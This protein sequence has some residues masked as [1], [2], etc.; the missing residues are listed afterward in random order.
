LFPLP[1]LLAPPLPLP[2]L[3]P[4]LRP[5]AY[6]APTLPMPLRFG[7]LALHVRVHFSLHSLLFSGLLVSG[8][9]VSGLPFPELAMPLW[10]VPSVSKVTALAWSIPLLKQR[11]LERVLCAALAAFVLCV[12]PLSL[13]WSPKATPSLAV[14]SADAP[15]GRHSRR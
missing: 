4:L 1:R 7:P 9:P 3:R 2:S 14:D 5:R 13:H 8:L 6:A 10:V 15:L 11:T 12:I